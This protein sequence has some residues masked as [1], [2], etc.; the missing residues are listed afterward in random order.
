MKNNKWMY[1][2]NIDVKLI[3][4]IEKTGRLNSEYFS[5]THTLTGFQLTFLIA[6]FLSVFIQGY[7]SSG[8]VKAKRLQI[9]KQQFLII[10]SI[11]SLF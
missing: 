7:C 11:I 3:T 8:T 1:I 6:L 4:I 5:E 2:C 10:A 9:I